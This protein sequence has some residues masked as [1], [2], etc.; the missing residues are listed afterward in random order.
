MLATTAQAL[1]VGGET[2]AGLL[3]AMAES[4]RCAETKQL[5]HRP[6]ELRT[7]GG[8]NGGAN[9]GTN[10]GTNCGT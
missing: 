10:G 1:G 3:R 2:P 4:Y 7:N 8:T 9:G 6:R 5:L